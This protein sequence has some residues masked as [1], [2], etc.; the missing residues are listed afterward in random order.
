MKQLTVIVLLS[1]L[2]TACDTRSNQKDLDSPNLQ[3]T[4]P[5]ESISPEITPIPPNNLETGKKIIPNENI[6]SQISKDFVTQITE[7]SIS[8]MEIINDNSITACDYYLSEEKNS[9][10]IAIILNK[11]LNVEKQKQ[12]AQ[13]TKLVLKTDPDISGDHYIAWAD[14]ET[15]ISNVNLVIDPNNFIRIDKNVERAIDNQGMIKL[16]SAISRRL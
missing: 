1:L 6:C 2:L 11:N 8:R 12:I 7:I 14:K 13:K 4:S 10:Y 9:P 3:T 16:A 5:S 15:R